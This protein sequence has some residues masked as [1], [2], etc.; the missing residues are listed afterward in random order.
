M[1]TPPMVGE[2]V[3]Q[4]KYAH[5]VKIG[6]FSPKTIRLKTTPNESFETTTPTRRTLVQKICVTVS[7]QHNQAGDPL[8]LKT[9]GFGVGSW[10]SQTCHTSRRRFAPTEKAPRCYHLRVVEKH[11]ETRV[12]KMFPRQLAVLG[13]HLLSNSRGMTHLY[14]LW[15]PGINMYFVYIYIYIYMLWWVPGINYLDW[16]S[17]GKRCELDTQEKYT[18]WNVMNWY[19][20]WC[21]IW[22]EVHLLKPSLLISTAIFKEGEVIFNK[23]VRLHSTKLVL[24]LQICTKLVLVLNHNWLVVSTHLKN[25]SQIGS[26]PQ[27][28]GENKKYLKPP[29]RWCMT[30][31]AIH[32]LNYGT[33]S[34]K[35]NLLLNLIFKGRPLE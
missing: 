27:V 9:A 22:K 13:I 1:W 31:G 20:N 16:K 17:P 33:T 11:H 4:Q 2:F 14:S 15:R 30:T 12:K 8:H 21:H 34:T 6:F 23:L 10:V 18:P 29:S 25:I 24:A 5:F 32:L 28:G 3:C 7:L 26:C 35:I 19:P